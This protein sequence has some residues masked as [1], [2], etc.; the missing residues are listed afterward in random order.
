MAVSSLQF[1]L[2]QL[3]VEFGC[4]KFSQ[5]VHGAAVAGRRSLSLIYDVHIH[6]Q[7]SGRPFKVNS[8]EHTLA[9]AFRAR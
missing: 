9:Q 7:N 1:L 5:L 4:F 8:F 3:Q 6:V 2:N